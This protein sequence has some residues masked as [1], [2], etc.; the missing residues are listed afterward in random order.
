MKI[1]IKSNFI[2]T[3]NLSC[4]FKRYFVGISANLCISI[5]SKLLVN[6]QTKEQGKQKTQGRAH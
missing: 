6:L 2:I 3:K 5:N 1:Y 4:V